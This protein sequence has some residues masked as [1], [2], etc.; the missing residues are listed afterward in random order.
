VLLGH[1]GQDRGGTGAGISMRVHVPPLYNP[2]CPCTTRP[3]TLRTLDHLLLASQLV[4][5]LP[6][7]CIASY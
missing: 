3:M 2:L 4:T 7:T 1:K 6:Q 5:I